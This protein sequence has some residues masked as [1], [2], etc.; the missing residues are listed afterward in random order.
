MNERRVKEKKNWLNEATKREV[1]LAYSRP[2]RGF[3]VKEL[4][5][6]LK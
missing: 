6:V 1:L 5:E 4:I 3:K 2:S